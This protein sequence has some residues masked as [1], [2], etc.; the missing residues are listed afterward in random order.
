MCGSLWSRLICLSLWGGLVGLLLIPAVRADEPPTQPPQVPLCMIGD[1]ITW[2]GDG[3][4]W[5]QYLLTHLPNLA[6]VGTH[7]AVLGYSHAGEGGNRTTQVL[8][9]LEAIPDCPYYHLLIGTND[10]ASAKAEADVERVAAGTAERIVQIVTGLL[11]KPS[12]QRVFLASVLPCE[13]DNPFRDRANAAVN[14]LLRPRLAE[15][16]PGGQ[17]VWVEYEQPLRATPGWGPMIRL[18]PTKEGYQLLARLLAEALRAELKLSAELTAPRPRPGCGVRIT[19]LWT[20]E[21]NG[22][23]TEPVIAG[24]YTL[25]FDLVEVAPEGGKLVL[26]GEGAAPDKRFEQTCQLTA[27]QVGK[28]QVV[29]FFTGYAG[30]RYTTSV[31]TGEAAGCTVQRVL[32]E[33]RR[34]SGLASV[35]GTGSYLDTTTPPA[36]GELIESPR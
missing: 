4:Y 21:G 35:Y 31:L 10:D 1:S 34:P 15:T 2:S 12:V 8:A 7:S 16:F 29:Q 3:D 17:V 18:H 25:S 24:W 30:Y 28:R 22:R 26:R 20:G 23:T 6:F 19:N 14:A 11:A 13:T 32:L 36:P 9:R 27:D 33:K 5:R